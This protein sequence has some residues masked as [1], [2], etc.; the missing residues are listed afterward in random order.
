MADALRSARAAETMPALVAV[1]VVSLLCNVCLGAAL[2]VHC[3]R[4]RKVFRK[5]GPPTGDAGSSEH[6]SH[7][8]QPTVA[9]SEL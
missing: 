8:M 4:R 5:A 2:L 1:V 7:M 9:M 3:R 6:Y